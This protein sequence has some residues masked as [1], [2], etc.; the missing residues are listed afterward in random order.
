M[1]EAPTI[2]EL[3]RNGTMS[4]EMAATLWAAVDERWSFV[5][6]AIPRLA[7]K[8]TVLNAMLA[9]LP[10]EVPV[11]SL[12][13]DEEE[14]V[15]LKRAATGGYLVVGEFSQAPVPT[16]IWGAPV[17]RL[18]DTLT[19]GYSLATAL[20]A[21]GLQ[22]TFDAICLGNGVTDEQASCI[23]LVLY[24]RRFGSGHDTLWRRLA[25]VHEIDRVE[26][27]RPVGR[28]L[29]RWVEEGDRFEAVA[30]SQ[31]L[32]AGAEEL[33]SRAARMKEMAR[34]GQTSAADVA[35]MIAEQRRRGEA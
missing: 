14:M 17:H 21:P 25:E 16:Y 34:L 27:G 5:V 28:L 22:E 1:S 8:T 18:F 20:H 10:P 11:H 24:L 15:R 9:L 2:L 19:V 4:A 7:G 31:L 29:H 35:R 6:V 33:A 13:G 3:V 30:G 26:G 12:R 23:R 32:Q